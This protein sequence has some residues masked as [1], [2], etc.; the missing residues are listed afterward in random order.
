LPE[1][2]IAR[3]GAI[4]GS[5]KCAGIIQPSKKTGRIDCETT[6]RIFDINF[7]GTLNFVQALEP[8]LLKRREAYTVQALRASR[9]ERFFS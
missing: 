3:H 1:E 7:Y 8:D 4:D 2:T 9:P 5:I 6:K